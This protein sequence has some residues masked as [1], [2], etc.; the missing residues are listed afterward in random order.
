MP[1]VHD[2][3]PQD[4]VE[5][6]GVADSV[7]AEALWAWLTAKLPLPKMPFLVFAERSWPNWEREK[8]TARP[9]A[10]NLSWPRAPRG[11]NMAESPG[12][13]EVSSGDD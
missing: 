12:G 10:K 3:G 13:E 1:A 9:R 7:P 6:T 11:T 8:Y 5:S 2:V 4:H